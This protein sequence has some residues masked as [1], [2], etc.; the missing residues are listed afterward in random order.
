MPKIAE[1]ENVV[2]LQA[3]NEDP[4]SVDTL[5]VEKRSG[6][7]TRHWSG[8]TSQ[9]GLQAGEEQGFCIPKRL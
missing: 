2:V 5:S 1:T 9:H 4:G 3:I 8:W 6:M 7:F